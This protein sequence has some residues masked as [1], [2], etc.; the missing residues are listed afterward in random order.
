MNVQSVLRLLSREEVS[1]VDSGAEHLRMLRERETEREA[2]RSRLHGL[3]DQSHPELPAA[4]N[5]RRK[6]M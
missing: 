5:R 6:V 2:E 4:V 1:R 3:L